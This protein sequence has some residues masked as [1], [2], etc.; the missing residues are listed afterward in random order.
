MTTAQ[1]CG[2]F[3]SLTHRPLLPPGNAPG[4]HFCQRLSRPQGHSA[5]G[6]ILCQ[7]INP[8]TRTWIEPATFRF[9][10]QHLNH[11]ATADYVQQNEIN[12]ANVL[13]DCNNPFI[14]NSVLC[15][16]VGKRRG[17]VIH[18]QTKRCTRSKESKSFVLFCDTKNKMQ[19][20]YETNQFLNNNLS[21]L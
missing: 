12:K 1:D 7:R 20:F 14:W 8:M 9:V 4:T 2:K 5:I 6:R 11:C 15:F 13:L 21:K 3:V 18:F 19:L 17:Y 10:A 16:R